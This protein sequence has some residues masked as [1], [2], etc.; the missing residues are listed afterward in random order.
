M[1]NSRRTLAAV[2]IGIGAVVYGLSP[3]DVIPELFTGPL[4]FGDDIA[5]LVASAIGIWKLLSGRQ[6][7]SGTVP[8]A[9]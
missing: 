8:P 5:V 7:R 4:G 2:L 6:P 3:I 1:S 9:G